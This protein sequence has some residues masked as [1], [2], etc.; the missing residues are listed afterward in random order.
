[1][2]LDLKSAV[3]ECAFQPILPSVY[4]YRYRSKKAPSGSMA[5]AQNRFVDFEYRALNHLRSIS[6]PHMCEGRLGYLLTTPDSNF[7]LGAEQARCDAG[8][9]IHDEASLPESPTERLFHVLDHYADQK[10][11]LPIEIK[12]PAVRLSSDWKG[13]MYYYSS[14]LRYTQ[15]ICSLVI[16]QNPA[17]PQ[18]IA[19]CPRSWFRTQRK[20]GGNASVE[21]P[22]SPLTGTSIEPLPMAIAPAIMPTPFA[23]ESLK[24][25]ELF[26]HNPKLEWYVLPTFDTLQPLT[27]PGAIRIRMSSFAM[28]PSIRYCNRLANCYLPLTT[29]TT[30]LATNGLFGEHSR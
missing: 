24:A 6:V 23:N 29:Q 15:S 11:L 14:G 27:I 28:R 1:M 4:R 5:S 10:M 13:V 3:L 30:T 22:D 2:L 20:D 17:A 21:W 7:V 9:L 18:L 19:I 16:V 26:Y 8:I 25:F 12:T